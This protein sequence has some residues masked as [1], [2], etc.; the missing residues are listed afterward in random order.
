M[1]YL[2]D[3]SFRY[4]TLWMTKKVGCH[5]ERSEESSL[6]SRY[7]ELDPSFRYTTLWMTEK[8]ECHSEP[9]L[10]QDKLREV[11]YHRR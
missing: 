2:L 6:E 1:Y 9:F 7:Y 10:R 8:V 5:S 3:P 4:T 11:L